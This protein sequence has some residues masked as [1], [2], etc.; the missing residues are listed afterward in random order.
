MTSPEAAR[1]RRRGPKPRRRK[2]RGR[3]SGSTSSASVRAR[4]TPNSA[5]IGPPRATAGTRDRGAGK[6]GDDQAESGLG[7]EGSRLHLA[8]PASSTRQPP[9]PP[10][11]RPQRPGWRWR[12]RSR[13]GEHLVA[14]PSAV[15][16]LMMRPGQQQADRSD[17]RRRRRSRRRRSRA[18]DA[19]QGVAH[20]AL[21]DQDRAPDVDDEGIG[22]EQARTPPRGWA[23]RRGEW[24]RIRQP[25]R[26]RRG[27]ERRSA[28]S[29]S[30]ARATAAAD[31]SMS[32]PT[33][34]I[35]RPRARPASR[36]PIRPRR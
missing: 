16:G 32:T 3:P 21:V 9:H 4:S 12:I 26:P 34:R 18:V 31:G 13:P 25:G 7:R 8:L 23:A 17:R 6:Q 36:V 11:R 35:P 28:I 22:M 19:E 30:S 14:P 27:R 1:R 29:M 15:G 24:T 33:T 2:A 5:G 20:G 10:A